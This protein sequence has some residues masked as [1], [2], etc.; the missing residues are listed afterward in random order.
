MHLKKQFLE[1]CSNNKFQQNDAQIKI[2]ELLINFNKKISIKQKF[3]K[4]FIKNHQKLGF[5]LQGDV[6]VGKTMLLNFF[7]DHLNISKKRMHFNEFMINFHDFRHEKKINEKNNSIEK[8]VKNL[9]EKVDL[10]YLDEF[11]VTNIVD[12]MILGKLFENIFNENIKILISSNIKIEE[13]YKDGLQREQFVPFI[14]IIKK[15]CTEHFLLIGQDYRKSGQSKLNGYFYPLNS[16]TTFQINQLF[17]QLTKKKEETKLKLEIK[18]RVFFINRFFEGIARFDFK[19]LCHANL[20]A[21]D[22]IVIS[23]RCDFIVLDNVPNFKDE[24]V[25]EQQRF[26]TLIDILY[27]KKIQMIVSSDFNLENFTS[28]RK[29]VEPYKRTISRLFELT[30]SNV[31]KN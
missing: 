23:N 21:E 11:Q 7:F 31:I 19:E 16:K 2:L 4:L 9:K 30:S 22:Y 20:A 17:R 5:Y 12:A 25:N 10:L 24:L 27:E 15:F 8:F 6:G 26:I 28:S 18:G 13:L 14:N 1:Y 29:L 3:L